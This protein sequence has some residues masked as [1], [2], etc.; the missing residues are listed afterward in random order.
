MI[1]WLFSHRLAGT[2]LKEMTS[3]I[4]KILTIN[5]ASSSSSKTGH[6]TPSRTLHVAI[7]CQ[8][9]AQHSVCFVEKLYEQ[10]SFE[11]PLELEEGV[12]VEV[13][14][15]HCEAT[16]GEWLNC[17]DA[18]WQHSQMSSKNLPTHKDLILNRS[19]SSFPT[20]SSNQIEAAFY[21]DPYAT[22]VDV[23][24]HVIDFERGIVFNK[25]S[26]NEFK[27]RSAIPSLEGKVR[28]SWVAQQDGGNKQFYCGAGIL[29]YSVH[30]QTGEVV[31]LLGHMT[32][33]AMAWCDFGGMKNH[34][35]NFN[36]SKLC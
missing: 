15:Q 29:F 30:P 34:R 10:F 16:K 26:R 35:Y 22:K 31:F 1:E 13:K 27:I 33:S 11:S 7:G 19:W 14:R 21:Q 3:Q 23:G 9:G 36:L 12:K 24:K 4:N 25:R 6:S 17:K 28:S 5:I 32:Y 18:V 2:V 20:E 8:N